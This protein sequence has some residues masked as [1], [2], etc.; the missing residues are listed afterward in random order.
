MSCLVF[1]FFTS[2]FYSPGFLPT[3]SMTHM[4]CVVFFLPS[5]FLLFSC[6][7]KKRVYII[8]SPT[9]LQERPYN[10]D[11]T[12]SRLLSEVKHDLARLVLRWG[13]TLESLV[14]FF[15]LQLQHP[16]LVLFFCVLAGKLATSTS[17][18]RHRIEGLVCLLMV[19]LLVVCLLVVCLFSWCILEDR[20]GWWGGLLM[21]EMKKGME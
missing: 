2:P 11:S 6:H 8:P 10:H 16:K 14:L 1:L 3:N 4:S 9:F 12:A 7:Y 5:L 18:A 20:R 19:C 15:C 21:E 17:L 13:T